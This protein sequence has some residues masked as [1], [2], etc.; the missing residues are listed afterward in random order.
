MYHPFFLSFLRV[1]L[2]RLLSYNLYNILRVTLISFLIEV[3]SLNSETF[4]LFRRAFTRGSTS[5]PA[6]SEATSSTIL[7]VIFIGT[8]LFALSR[9]INFSC[10]Q[11]THQT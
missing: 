7:L 1:K 3:A 6:T 8:Q 11:S 2:T 9:F 10:G 4:I 5:A